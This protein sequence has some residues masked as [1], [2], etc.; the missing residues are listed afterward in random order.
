MSKPPVL[1]IDSD[2]DLKIK[3]S[4]YYGRYYFTL[5]Q[6]ARQLLSSLNF[7]DGESIPTDLFIILVA[8]GQAFFP[9]E[10]ADPLDIAESITIP[11]EDST[12][13]EGEIADIENYIDTWDITSTQHTYVISVLHEAKPHYSDTTQESGEDDQSRQGVPVDL[14]QLGQDLDVAKSTIEDDYSTL[15]GYGINDSAAK[16]TLKTKYEKTEEAS[17]FDIPGIDLIEAHFL[18]DAGY[19]SLAEI[20]ASEETE[21]TDVPYVG[22]TKV[23]VIRDGAAELV[24]ESSNR[25][26]RLAR[27]T[28]ADEETVRDQLDKLGHYGVAPSAAEQTVIEAFTDGQSIFDISGIGTLSGHFLLK[29]GY[30]SPKTIAQATANELK[31]VRYIGDERAPAI[32]QNSN[33]SIADKGGQD[34]SERDKS[35]TPNEPEGAANDGQTLTTVDLPASPSITHSVYPPEMKAV[36]QWLI[37]KPDDGRKIPRAPWNNDGEL[38]YVDGTD[39]TNWTDFETATESAEMFGDDVELAFALSKTD[40]F[41]FVDYDDVRNDNGVIQ[42]VVREHIRQAKSYSAV[43]TSG[44]GTHLFV[45][46]S[47]SADVKSITDDFDSQQGGSIEV[48]EKERFVAMSGMHIDGTPRSVRPAPEFLR[49]LED[50]FASVTAS[51][52]DRTNTEQAKSR[53]ELDN[54]DQTDSIKDVFAAIENVSPGDIQLRSQK[55]NKRSDGSVSYDPSWTYSESGTRL[56]ELDD[57][58]VYRD[59][60]IALDALQIVA[61]E[62]GIIRNEQTYPEGGDFWRAVEALRTRGAQ[63]P[64]YSPDLKANE[65]TTDISQDAD[66]TDPQADPSVESLQ[67]LLNH[68]EPVREWVAPE[69]RSYN[70]QLAIRLADKFVE[71]GNQFALPPVAVLRAAEF[72]VQAQRADIIRGQSMEATIGAVFNVASAVEGYP[73][74]LKLIAAHLEQDSGT[75]Q[76]KIN[77]LINETSVSDDYDASDIFVEPADYLPYFARQLNVTVSDEQLAEAVEIIENAEIGGGSSPVSIAAGA[78]YVVCNRD[79]TL[80]V[81]QED[82]ADVAGISTVT[83]RNAKNKF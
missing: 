79:P 64:E 54:L 16:K 27:K 72:F 71:I 21:L 60:M 57:F 9:T 50:T 82:L 48:Y 41:V 34:I 1:H 19:E 40:R 18:I 76:N 31:E 83:V 37:W 29:A 5:S 6:D 45:K 7:V 59:G 33:Q 25:V 73:R 67:R 32:L 61:L 81:G 70:E 20:A 13:T 38:V 58:W 62:E 56:A 12:L 43:S 10:T 30:D 78:L 24:T 8:A 75:I 47:L 68:G 26:T 35:D 17:L 4:L 65:N 39:P 2:G 52:P 49:E 23:T 42:P 80:R 14:E 11:T 28:G 22:Q 55:T 36:D 77:R 63:I 66:I 51:K 3:G 15:H 53:E 44:T 46:G 74:P 69:N